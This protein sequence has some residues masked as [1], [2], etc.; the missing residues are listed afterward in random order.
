MRVE[1]HSAALLVDMAT[2]PHLQ[3]AKHHG[4]RPLRRAL[5]TLPP[6][7][8]PSTSTTLP[9]TPITARWLPRL[10]RRRLTAPD[11]RGDGLDQSWHP[12]DRFPTAA[13]EAPTGCDPPLLA[14]MA[15]GGAALGR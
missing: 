11:D 4:D 5:R 3:I 9:A 15:A 13:G 14:P 12:A 1:A 6:V 8:G 2:T 7:S 10:W